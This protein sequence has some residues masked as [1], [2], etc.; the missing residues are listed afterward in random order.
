LKNMKKV[1][2]RSYE[3]PNLIEKHEKGRSSIL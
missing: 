1:V 2:H 3:R